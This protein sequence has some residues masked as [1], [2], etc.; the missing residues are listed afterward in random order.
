MT[1]QNVALE[2][3]P[4]IVEMRARYERIAE[5]PT[6]Q[7]V[8][9]LTLLAGLY[10]AISP[11][12]VGFGPAGGNLNPVNLICGLAVTTLALGYAAVYGRTHGLSW[13]TPVL[14]AWSIIAPWVV[15]DNPANSVIANN[16]IAGAVILVLGL[17]TTVMGVRRM[18]TRMMRSRMMDNRP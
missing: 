12:V 17:L 1:H 5:T 14:G 18:S 9:G 15:L 4:D 3:H 6:A 16:V 11:W 13:V 8:E 2:Q 7:L 10:L